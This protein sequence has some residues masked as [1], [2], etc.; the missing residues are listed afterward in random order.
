MDAMLQDPAL[1]RLIDQVLAARRD[2][3]TLDIRGAGTKAFYGGPA[4]GEPLEVRALAGISSHEPTELVVTVRAGTPL[5]DL[6][7]ALAQHGQCLAF[8]PPRFADPGSDA[9]T[10]A[11]VDADVDT[12]AD[13][14]SGIGGMLGGTRGGTVG[15]MVAAGLAGPA[16][17][18]VGGVRDHLLGA[19]LLNGRGEVLSFGGQVMKNV[20][21]YDVSRVLAGS[22]GVLG[23]ILEV[24]L[25]VLPVPTAFTTLAFD[26]DEAG[27]LQRLNGWRRQPLP[28]HASS[29]H[30]GRLMLRLAGARAAVRAACE[31][32]SGPQGGRAVDGNEAAAWWRGV[33]DQRLPFFRLRPEALARGEALWRL[34]VPAATPC[35]RSPGDSFIEWGGALRWVRSTAPTAQMRALAAQAGGHATRMR[36][37]APSPDAGALSDAFAPL[38]AVLMRVHQGLKQA[39]DPDRVFNPGR[40]YPEL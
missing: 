15:G 31:Q 3:T 34:S 33:R 11:D 4:R 37:A 30:A 16:R 2:R 39:F 6:E 23:V 40:L 1:R 18:A 10:D 9:D 32:L 14:D 17:A 35:L 27:A 29:W 24:S 21:G 12:D 36:A 19:T 20:A 28:I 13:T 25:K 38:P 5:Q 8:E 7:A 22:M 26:V